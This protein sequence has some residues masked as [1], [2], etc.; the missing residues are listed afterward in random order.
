MDKPNFPV[1]EAKVSVPASFVSVW[2]EGDEGEGVLEVEDVEGGEEAGGAEAPKALPWCKR[3]NTI[4]KQINRCM[5]FIERTGT[6]NNLFLDD[7]PDHRR[8]PW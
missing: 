8:D 6:R 2:G 4:T 3:E 7:M 1:C 5:I